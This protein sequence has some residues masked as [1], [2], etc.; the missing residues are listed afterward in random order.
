M[1]VVGWKLYYT[2]L[3]VVSS[4]E[5]SWDEA[6]V[7]NVLG[8]IVYYD[9]TYKIYRN[10]SLCIEPFRNVYFGKDYYWQ[11]GCGDQQD[12]PEVVSVKLG[13]EVPGEEWWDAY[14]RMHQDRNF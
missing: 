10:S 5:K 12:V 6:P 2:D 11:F 7:D 8:M 1:S 14:N 3:S 13:K 4:Q 9:K